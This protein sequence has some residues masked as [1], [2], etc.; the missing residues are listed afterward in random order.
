MRMPETKEKDTSPAVIF[1]VELLIVA[2]IAAILLWHQGLL[3]SAGAAEHRMAVLRQWKLADD[4]GVTLKLLWV[5]LGFGGFIAVVLYCI[6]QGIA[7]S[8]SREKT[9]KVRV[10]KKKYRSGLENGVEYIYWYM[11]TFETESQ[12][13]LTLRVT[14]KEYQN[15]K[16]Q[17]TG[18][19]TRRG[20]QFL[21]FQLLNRHGE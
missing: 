8:M 3:I 13:E 5:I 21:D 1:I 19:L 15:I 2:G 11:V 6:A 17:D 4:L 10:I 12:E 7:N 20:N 9:E 18:I 16:E 14:K